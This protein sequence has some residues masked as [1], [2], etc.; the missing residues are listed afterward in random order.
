MSEKLQKSAMADLNFIFTFDV[1]E[2]ERLQRV[3][4]EQPWG[5]RVMGEIIA[6]SF[7]VF[8]VRD[9]MCSMD[10]EGTTSRCYA[11]WHFPA[12]QTCAGIMGNLE[13]VINDMYLSLSPGPLFT[14]FQI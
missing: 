5:F 9:Y 4:W 3:G 13:R 12:T 6:H 10:T 2:R 11:G 7:S 8:P 1:L 14:A